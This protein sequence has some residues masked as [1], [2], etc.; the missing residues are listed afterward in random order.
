MVWC[1]VRDTTNLW[2]LPRSTTACSHPAKPAKPDLLIP[3]WSASLSETDQNGISKSGFA[4]LAGCEQ[5]VVLLGK[6]H[7]FVVSRTGHQTILT[8]RKV[9]CQ[10]SSIIE[11]F[12]QS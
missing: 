5:A 6:G 9:P 8:G 12:C 2:P 11:C 3:F 10:I 4:G 7:K 1:P